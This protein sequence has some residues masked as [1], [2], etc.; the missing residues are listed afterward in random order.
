MKK[1]KE[2]LL[3]TLE[4]L[5]NEEYIKFK[6]YL[7]EGDFHEG[8]PGIR[9]SRLEKA[10]RH[11]VVDLMEQ[12]YC[13]K[14]PRITIG[15]LKDM[16][17]NDLAQKLQEEFNQETEEGR[18]KNL[19]R[20]PSVGLDTTSA[21]GLYWDMFL[22]ER[23]CDSCLGRIVVE[24]LSLRP[25][26]I[27]F[28][29]S[30]AADFAEE[31]VDSPPSPS[32][33][34]PR[35]V[36][37]INPSNTQDMSQEERECLYC[38]KRGH[39]IK[40]CLRLKWKTQRKTTANTFQPR[41][42]GSEQFATRTDECDGPSSDPCFKQ[43]TFEGL[44]SL[45][46]EWADQQPVQIL[47]NTAGYQS[48]I[49]FN[50]LPFS[51]NSACGH[52]SNLSGIETGRV[53]RPLHF[54]HIKSRLINGRFPVAVCPTLPVR[55]ITML[56]GNDIAGGKV[57]PSSDVSD[58]PPSLSDQMDKQNQDIPSAPSGPV[59]AR[60]APFERVIVG[61]VGPLPRTKTGFQYLLTI[62]C[63]STGFPEVVPL[64]KNTATAV[65]KALTK[66]FSTL[67]LPT[68][69][70][71]DRGTHF[72]S[73][74]FKQALNSL[75]IKHVVSSAYHPKSQG[76]LEQW[77]KTLKSMLRK[78]CVETYKS[79]DEGI[80]FELVALRESFGFS[81]SQLVFGHTLHDY[82]SKFRKQLHRA[83]SFAKEPLASSQ[84]TMKNKF[85]RTAT[86]RHFEVG[87]RV[88][89]RLPNPGS[90]LPVRFSGPD[91]ILQKQ[92]DTLYMIS[93]PDRR[94]KTRVCHIDMLKLHLSRD[95]ETISR[96]QNEC[97]A[98]RESPRDGDGL[99]TG[100]SPKQ[101]GLLP[102]LA[103]CEFGKGP[104]PRPGRRVRR[105]G[106]GQVGPIEEIVAAIT[107]FPVPNTRR[108]L[109]CFL[110]MTGIYR[111]FCK[112]FSSVVPPPTNITSLPSPKVEYNWTPECQNAFD[113]LQAAL[114]RTPVLAAPDFTR[115]ALSGPLLY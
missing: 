73:K 40:N 89:A 60:G 90:S 61:C 110:G 113:H 72:Q 63:T 46:D 13:C 3:N 93:T 20:K 7:K 56:M 66:V 87:D 2:T 55:G 34:K 84:I 104:V 30:A 59:P 81:P 95:N 57:T 35:A 33:V 36:P 4:D 25:K 108:A 71:T 21:G 52:S 106:P 32:T 74:L 88:F 99:P 97:S 1:H 68:T 50:A 92:G 67:A 105:V 39:I 65:A 114:R 111:S 62:T 6:W 45:T 18:M 101:S 58:V 112:N 91:S 5:T 51:K 12:T 19:D 47:R 10:E 69:V 107:D 98:V 96:E 86:A 109:C 22:L 44:V 53:R 79:W 64:R 41:G 26:L 78:Y 82:G 38:H 24:L 75:D 31:N 49:L 102:N 103:K 94:R 29:K 100:P 16:N 43:F 27:E 80:L 115:P 42:I 8:F 15:I 54:V 17:R 11:K 23:F 28:M 70:Q 37:Q 9:E 48:L 85:D 77:H 76:T 83:R 14:A